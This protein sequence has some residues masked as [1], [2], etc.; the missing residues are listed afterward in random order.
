MRAGSIET[1]RKSA[2]E[3]MPRPIASRRRSDR[4]DPLAHE[5]NISATVILKRA[6]LPPGPARL[7]KHLARAVRDWSRLEQ[8]V[9][10]RSA[11]ASLVNDEI[12]TLRIPASLR[13][14]IDRRNKRL[15]EGPLPGPRGQC[16]SR[17]RGRNRYNKGRFSRF[18]R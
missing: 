9:G 5:T 8:V 1:L 18:R 3:K 16:R 15:P 11:S 12:Q 13:E 17:E 14:Q 10:G 2:R 4:D 7:T 6:T